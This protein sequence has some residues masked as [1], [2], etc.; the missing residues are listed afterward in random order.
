MGKRFSEIFIEMLENAPLKHISTI[1]M[2]SERGI[3]LFSPDE[4]SSLINVFD[5]AIKRMSGMDYQ[6]LKNAQEDPI[7]ELT[8]CK[9]KAELVL[10][11]LKEQKKKYPGKEETEITYWR[12]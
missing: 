10:K 5:T 6:G 11:K 12:E 3:A 8:R 7:V 9:N 2:I 4:V 1:S